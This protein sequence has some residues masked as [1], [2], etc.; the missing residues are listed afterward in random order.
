MAHFKAPMTKKQTLTA[1]GQSTGV[2]AAMQLEELRDEKNV[3]EERCQKLQ[4]QLSD[5]LNER[6]QWGDQVG[7]ARV[8]LRAGS[9]VLVELVVA[10]PC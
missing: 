5:L 4:Q 10:M 1:I 9:G 3:L 8:P 7:G 6:S 2:S